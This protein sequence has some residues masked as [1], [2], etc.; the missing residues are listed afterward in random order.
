M[1]ELLKG[2][3]AAAEPTRL[4]ILGLCA[5]A[6][7]TVSDL[8]DVLGQSQ[9]RISRHLKLLVEAGLLVRSQDGPWAWYRL[10]DEGEGANLAQVMVDLLP[11]DDRRHATDLKRLQ[12]TSERWANR[13]ADYFREHAADWDRIRALHTDQ[14]RVDRA[15]MGALVE[16]PME[17]LLDIG[18]GAG[19]V[20]QLAGK[21]AQTA[22]GI[23]SSR[24]MLNVA[25]HNLFQAG[26]R[27][28]QVRQ[29]DML[30]LPFED[31][32]FSTITMNMVLHYAERPQEAIQEAARVLRPGGRLIIVDFASHQLDELQDVH[33][34]RW[35]GFDDTQVG[36]W[37]RKAGLITG[38]P[39]RLHGGKLT[40]VLWT[41]DRAAND[42]P[43]FSNPAAKRRNA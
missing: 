20:L 14:A 40:V 30:T 16:A 5:H 15:L 10:P 42:Q 32:S 2:L 41:A 19:H 31:Q 28:C 43:R 6:E 13:V 24:D 38:K 8:V 25:R 39:R 23:D 22:V 4:R 27:H 12:S 9:P 26:L 11:P 18:T 33:A 35:L 3:R 36:E 17:A 7:L 34:H 37:H 29:A 21:E 1:E